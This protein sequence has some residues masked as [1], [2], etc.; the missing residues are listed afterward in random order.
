[1]NI[2]TIPKDYYPAMLTVS[3]VLIVFSITAYILVNNETI[4]LISMAILGFGFAS[5]IFNM[6][7][8]KKERDKELA[9]VEEEKEQGK[10]G[11]LFRSG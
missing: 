11:K 4:R 10:K 5:L 2:P 7:A 9:E 8:W 3:L 6:K 1:M